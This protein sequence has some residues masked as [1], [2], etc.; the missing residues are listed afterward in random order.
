MKNDKVKIILNIHRQAE[1]QTNKQT[2]KALLNSPHHVRFII[3]F[4][5]FFFRHYYV[6]DRVV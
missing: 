6:F 2:K 1:R 5:M 3:I 4:L